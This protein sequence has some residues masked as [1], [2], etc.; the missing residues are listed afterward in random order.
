LHTCAQN[1]FG[2]A[3]GGES[4]H[5]R[6]IAHKGLLALRW[7]LGY[8]PPELTEEAC[9][10][11]SFYA[12]RASDMNQ[13]D[14]SVSH[15]IVFSMDRALQLYALLSS[16]CELALNPAGL[17]VIYRC[18]SPEHVLAY[19]EL[20]NL[21]AGQ[22]V[23]FLQEQV[24]VSFR[25]ALLNVLRELH[26]DKVFFLVDDA[27]FV[28][29]I[30]MRHF[31][32]EDVCGHV[33]SLRHGLTLRRSY[34]V[35]KPQSLPTFL[36]AKGD[37]APSA[38]TF[39][40]R[41]GEGVL[42]WGYPLSLDGHLYNR[43]EFLAMAALI[44]FR[45]PNTLEAELQKFNRIFRMRNGICYRNPAIVNIPCNKVQADFPNRHG[46]VDPELLLEKWNAGFMIDYRRLR[47]FRPESTHQEIDLQFVRRAKPDARSD[48]H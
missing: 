1:R 18:S 2:V 20:K 12:A 13:P 32:G 7:L 6:R 21:M 11:A 28:E 37:L 14:G 25:D 17:T 15:G 39:R 38:E 47:G 9:L 16:Y 45:S 8:E 4:V 36:A 40:W 23:R 27:V 19:E 30:D 31:T 44:P 34:V 22:P 24:A 43:R 10:F 48:E 46:D 26:A 3:T 29:P 42:E 33:P 41:W 35:N 5:L